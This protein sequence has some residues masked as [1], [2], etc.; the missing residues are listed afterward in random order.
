V[1]VRSLETVALCYPIM[2]VGNGFRGGVVG[3]N[4]GQLR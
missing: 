4:G 3:V 1:S 2:P